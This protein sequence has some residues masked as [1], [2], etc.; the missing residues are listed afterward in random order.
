MRRLSIAIISCL[1]LTACGGGNKLSFKNSDEVIK[2]YKAVTE[3]M[4]EAERLEFRRNMFL[5]AWTSEKPEQDVTVSDVETA[6]YHER[7]TLDLTGP[8]ATPVAKELALKGV[9]KMDGKT[10]AQVN[11]LGASLSGIAV[12]T[13]VQD[14]EEK[15]VTVDAAIAQLSADKETW[16]ARKEEAVAAEAALVAQ[17]KA[18]KPTIKSAKIG[19]NW[20]GVALQGKL[21]L[22]SPHVD[23]IND[24]RN[25]FTIEHDGYVVHYFRVLGQLSGNKKEGAFNLN[26]DP[27]TFTNANGVSLAA[28][29]VMPTEL[30]AYSYSFRP[31][32][33]RTSG[34]VN[35]W[36]TH[37]Y[38]LDPML[39]KALY[40]LPAALK[41]CDQS[42]EVA[43]KL[44][45]S[46]EEQIKRLNNNEFDELKR[47]S[48]RFA[49]SCL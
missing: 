33:V 16:K 32:W 1:V 24:F 26:L 49:E 5:V 44:R 47:I 46:F 7:N 42:I 12:T 37:E 23:P 3:N 29:Y 21:A 39:T 20:N 9:S 17:T 15:I 19:K 22:S 6:W 31:E 36:Q 2:S 35:G 45:V 10:A 8:G 13:R 41:S 11:A 28:D 4:T 30:S 43:Q 48:G 40:N 34:K 14:T 25:N 38:K 27:K 18:Y